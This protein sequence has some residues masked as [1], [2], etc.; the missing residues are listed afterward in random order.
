M[1]E[2]IL[3]VKADDVTEGKCYSSVIKGKPAVI[4]VIEVKVFG[5][6]ITTNP[7]LPGEDKTE[8]KSRMVKWEYRFSFPPNDRWKRGTRVTP[9]RDFLMALKEEV[10]C[11]D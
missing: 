7:G 6:T 3:T 2:G 10:D 5:E 4:R 9:M 1:M 11:G 8:T